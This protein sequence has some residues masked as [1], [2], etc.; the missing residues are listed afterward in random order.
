MLARVGTI[1]RYTELSKDW[2]AIITDAL[3]SEEGIAYLT[4]FGRTGESYRQKIKYSAEPKEGH[5]SPMP[6]PK[7]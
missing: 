6:S 4:V 2:A 5:W 3:E 7:K 1:V